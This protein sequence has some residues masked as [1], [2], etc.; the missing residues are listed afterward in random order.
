M[1]S[2]LNQQEVEKFLMATTSKVM[3]K[4]KEFTTSTLSQVGTQLVELVNTGL[5]GSCPSADGFKFIVHATV[6]EQWGQ[7]SLVGA[8]CEWDNTRDKVVSV[9]HNTEKVNVCLVVF[10]V[11][12]EEEEESDSGD[13]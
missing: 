5:P 3:A 11:H 7:G 9:T 12:I 4:G 1:E 13:E 6:Q 2:V 8:K 10:F